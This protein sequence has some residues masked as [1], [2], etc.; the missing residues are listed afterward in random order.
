MRKFLMPVE[1]S[2]ST[3]ERGSRRNRYPNVK[4][5]PPGEVA[6]GGDLR[7]GGIMPCR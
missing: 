7:E 3:F 1:P 5:A 6:P 2:N 4:F